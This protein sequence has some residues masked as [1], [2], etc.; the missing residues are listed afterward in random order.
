M[1]TKMTLSY[2]DFFI[3]YAIFWLEPTHTSSITRGLSQGLLKI[4]LQTFAKNLLK[5]SNDN[6]FK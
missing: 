4:R 5:F 6:Y 1:L 2:L 3:F